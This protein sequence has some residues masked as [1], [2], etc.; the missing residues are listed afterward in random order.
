MEKFIIAA[1]HPST[2]ISNKIKSILS[3][4]R[5][6]DHFSQ[7]FLLYWPNNFMCPM[8]FSDLFETKVSRL[9]EKEW[10][11]IRKKGNAANCTNYSDFINNKDKS[12]IFNTWRLLTFPSDLPKNFAKVLPDD[13]GKN[14]DLEFERIPSALREEYLKYVRKLRPSKA[15]INA[16]NKFI[17][18]NDIKKAIGVHIRRGDFVNYW[19]GRDKVSS[20]EKYFKKM[21]G[22]ILKNPRTKFF[23]T[24]DSMETQKKFVEKFGKSIII[25]PNKN[26]NRGTKKATKDALVDLFILSKTKKIFG[27]YLST[28]TEMA[29]WFGGCKQKVEIIGDKK[30]MQEVSRKNQENL[31]TKTFKA[32]IKKS[33]K[34]LLKKSFLFNKIHERLEYRSFKKRFSSQYK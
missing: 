8:E 31:Q 7:K 4:L 21:S 13:S 14:I 12:S 24:T 33:I 28:F 27:A 16:V 22:V 34:S 29:W 2:G 11:S 18:K 1:P 25:S 9:S 5:F 17:K 6:S 10:D 19:D 23:L 3:A 32:R 20:D 15:I 26:F 30:S